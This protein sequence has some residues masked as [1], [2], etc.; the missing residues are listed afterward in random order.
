MPVLVAGVKGLKYRAD[1]R[2][3]AVNARGRVRTRLT[4]ALV[5]VGLAL[6][7]VEA[8]RTRALEPVEV[9]LT[10]KYEVPLW[11]RPTGRDC[12]LSQ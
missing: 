4:G 2:I 9:V 8:G 6:H 7:P 5:D 12:T 3:D 10:L 1:E 11:K